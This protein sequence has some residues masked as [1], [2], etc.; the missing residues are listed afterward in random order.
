MAHHLEGGTTTPLWWG[1][2]CQRSWTVKIKWNGFCPVQVHVRCWKVVFTLK[3]VLRP[4]NWQ[5]LQCGMAVSSYFGSKK[6]SCQRSRTGLVRAAATAKLSWQTSQGK[7]LTD[8]DFQQ[9][10][11]HVR[12]KALK[13][14]NICLFFYSWLRVKITACRASCWLSITPS[15][16]W[17]RY[18]PMLEEDT[19][20]SHGNSDLDA[21]T[22]FM[23]FHWRIPA[24][25]DSQHWKRSLS[26][27][28]CK[29]KLKNRNYWIL[30]DIANV[31]LIQFRNRSNSTSK[32]T[33]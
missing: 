14:C 13:S 16:A 8:G 29:L 4:H 24:Y 28:L 17:R 7:T 9:T 32:F 23:I 25:S 11:L 27:A 22:F 10:L 15:N 31:H 3:T 1:Q 5:A 21:V 26:N 6:W 12:I 30:R 33:Q 2:V 18:F 19:S 20:N